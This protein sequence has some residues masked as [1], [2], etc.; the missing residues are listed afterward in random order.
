M[1]YFAFVV[2]KGESTNGTDD[3]PYGAVIMAQLL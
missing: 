2:S 1:I 3:T